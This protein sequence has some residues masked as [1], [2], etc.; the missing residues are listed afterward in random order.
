MTCV[1]RILPVKDMVKPFRIA[2][3]TIREIVFENHVVG[4]GSLQ[5]HFCAL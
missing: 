4:S 2:G 1:P 5:G 3:S